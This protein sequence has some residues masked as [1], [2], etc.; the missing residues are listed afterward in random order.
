[1]AQQ[2]LTSW[3]EI[4][5]YLG[6]GVRTVQRWEAEMGLPVRRPGPERHIVVAFPEEIDNW[7][8]GSVRQPT[9][10]PGNVVVTLNGDH[11]SVQQLVRL[12]DL[13]SKMTDMLHENRQ[14]TSRLVK[15]VERYLGRSPRTR[16]S[17]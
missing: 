10:V 11:I 8:K 16:A 15:Q 14:H 2:V 7:V 13:M 5:S 12:R 17:A 3:K 1:M 6:K 4:A 9:P